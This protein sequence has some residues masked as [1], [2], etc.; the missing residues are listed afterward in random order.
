MILSAVFAVCVILEAFLLFGRDFVLDKSRVA[1]LEAS[2]RQTYDDLKESK[3]RILERRNELIAAGDAAER[4]VAEAREATKT[5][6]GSR[7]VLPT[8]V[9]CVGQV[10]DGSCFRAPI[11]KELPAMPDEAQKLI[12]ECKNFVVVWAGSRDEA[13]RLVDQQFPFKL[14]YDV[15][16][17]VAVE[18]EAPS[19]PTEQ[20]A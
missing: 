15:G 3:K 6:E 9:H 19:I 1:A 18:T 10:G 4:Q 12:W 11:T 7:K 17:F 5:L 2:L 13:E 16:E 20:A 8:L 14:G